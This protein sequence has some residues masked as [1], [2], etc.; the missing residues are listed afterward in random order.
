MDKKSD[1]K[2]NGKQLGI[3]VRVV[4]H[5]QC[6]RGSKTTDLLCTLCGKTTW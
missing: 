4:Q 2:C 3:A 5:T 1:K 6:N